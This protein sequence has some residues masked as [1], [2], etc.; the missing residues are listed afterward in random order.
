M[1]EREIQAFVFVVTFMLVFTGLVAST[2]TGLITTSYN[3]PVLPSVNQDLLGGFQFYTS[4]NSNDTYFTYY[5]VNGQ[6]DYQLGG[7]YWRASNSSSG[8]ALGVK[9][10]WIVLWI[11]TDWCEF[12]SQDTGISRGESLSFSEIDEDMVNGTVKYNTLHGGGGGTWVLYY[13]SGDDGWGSS[14]EA[15]INEELYIIHGL[16]VGDTAP[17]NVIGLLFGLMTLTLPDI[18]Y[19][20]QLILATPIWAM[21]IILTFLFIMKMIPLFGD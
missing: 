21:A 2:P 1:A 3:N 18:P 8:L 6:Y 14:Y 9:Q 15:W 17:Q 19:L 20:F 5:G 12:K 4:Y 7:F 10:I 13:N 16:G 11:S